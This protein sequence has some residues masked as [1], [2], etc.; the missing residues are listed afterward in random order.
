MFSNILNRLKR[1][2]SP[3]SRED[4]R[5]VVVSGLPR[6]GTSMMMKM[7]Q[8]GGLEPLTDNIREADRDNPKGY[9]EFERV[10]KLDKGDTD[11]LAEANGKVVKVISALLRSLPEG[12]RYQVVFMRRNMAEILASQKRMLENRGEAT[13]SIED[14]EM[15]RV[16]ARHLPTVEKWL[17]NQAHVEVLYI[18]YNKMLEDPVPELA[19]LCRFLGRDLDVSAMADVVDP[20][21]YRNRSEYMA[22]S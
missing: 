8:A 9:F 17:E 12:H 10:K 19:R 20:A 14:E 7:L 18:D 21:L 5:I 2:A 1:A 11:W 15:E 13:D 4:S 22:G 6:S 3:D 16:F